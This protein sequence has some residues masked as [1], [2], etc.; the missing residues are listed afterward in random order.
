MPTLRGISNNTNKKA[1]FSQIRNKYQFQ[2]PENNLRSLIGNKR[3]YFRRVENWKLEIRNLIFLLLLTVFLSGCTAVGSAK[4]AALQVTSTP[5]ASVFL[6]G[7]HL[8]KTPFFSDQLKSGEYLLKVSVSE[9]SYVERIKLLSGSLTVVNREMN[10]NELAQSGET[11]WLE[12]DEKGVF[13]SSSPPESEISIDGRFSGK[14]PFYLSQIEP[15]EHKITLTKEGY[16]NREFVIRVSGDSRLMADVSL[17]SISIKE[18]VAPS[19]G[20]FLQASK[21]EI[22]KTPQGFL[23]VRKEPTTTASEIGRVKTGDKIEL[24]QES[25]DWFKIQFEGKQGWISKEYAKKL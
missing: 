1:C 9:S 4:P 16:L 22:L 19:P 11:L 17:A 10:K 6:D 3:A 23:R 15:G 21:V 20:S 12:P 13:I 2:I 14:T 18:G 5:E 8:G 25:E 24:L 7:K